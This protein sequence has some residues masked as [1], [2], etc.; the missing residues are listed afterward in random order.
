MIPK[1]LTSATGC[2]RVDLLTWKRTGG[3]SQN[4]LL[5]PWSLSHRLLISGWNSGQAWAADTYLGVISIELV[6]KAIGMSNITE[7]RNTNK[8]KRGP[9]LSLE[10]FQHSE[11]TKQGEAVKEKEKF[12][13][14]RCK[15]NDW[16]S[17]E[18]LGALSKN[19][20]CQVVRNGA[21]LSGLKSEWKTRKGRRT[22]RQLP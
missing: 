6:F 3:K 17:S 20:F 9:K 7:G 19:G 1:F 22:N 16:F 14:T 5:Y 2:I 12:W 15:E 4:S 11:V 18:D 13:P 8:E 10:A 21:E